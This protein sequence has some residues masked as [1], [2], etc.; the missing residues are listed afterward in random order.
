MNSWS[1]L[2]MLPWGWFWNIVETLHIF[3]DIERYV[4]KKISRTLKLNKTSILFPVDSIALLAEQR[5]CNPEMRVRI[6]LKSTFL[7]DFSSVSQFMKYSDVL[8]SGLSGEAY[9]RFSDNFYFLFFTWQ[10]RNSK[11]LYYY[12]FVKFS[13]CFHNFSSLFFGE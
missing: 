7:V 10:R 11:L 12:V 6:P 9:T 5:S 3:S 1:I 2:F 4:V 13:A 8:L